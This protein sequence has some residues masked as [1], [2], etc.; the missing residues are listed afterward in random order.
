MFKGHAFTIFLIILQDISVGR[1]ALQAM[2]MTN[3]RPIHIDLRQVL[4]TKLGRKAALIPGFVVRRLEKTICQDRLNRILEITFP[5]QGAEFCKGV[6]D[7]LNISLDIQ[8]IDN[9]PADGRCIFVSNHPLGGLD[10]IALIHFLTKHYGKDVRFVVNDLLTAVKP[11]EP[12]FI[13]INKHGS[14]SRASV[15]AL[16]NELAGDSPVIIFPAGLVSRRQPDGSIAD[17]EWKK[18]FINK[19]IEFRRDIVPLYFGGTNSD[20][21]YKFAS[22]RK[23]LGM[24]FNIEMI[25]LPREVFRAENSTFRIVCGTPLSHT[26]LQGGRHA[27]IEASQIRDAVYRLSQEQNQTTL[28]Q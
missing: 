28:P 4:K 22:R 24:K 18:T 12:V 17:L 10:G 16:D 23:K 5:R 26:S 11:L 9:L 8:G 2:T 25:Y 19:A 3:D 21:F 7:D 1:P 27:D 15:K 14:Q 20:F 13:P 6:L